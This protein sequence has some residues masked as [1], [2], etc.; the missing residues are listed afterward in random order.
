MIQPLKKV[1]LLFLLLSITNVFGQIN[2]VD[3]IAQV[4]SYWE[5]GEKQNYTISHEKVKLTDSDTTSRELTTYD[6]EVTVLEQTDKS[7]TV[8]WLYKNINTDNTNPTI[9]K[10]LN[11]SKEMTVIFK[12]DELGVFIE[13]VNWQE[14]KDYILKASAALRKEFVNKPE[15]ENILD[16]LEATYS[17][18]TAIESASIRDIQQFHTFH[19][20]Q[21]KLGEFLEG[22]MKVPNIYGPEPFDSDFTVY[23]DEI[24]EENNNFVMRASQEVDKEQLT[25]ATLTYLTTLAEKMKVNPPTKED[26]KELKNETV[27]ASRIHGTGWVIYSVQTITVTAENI[28]NIEERIIEIKEATEK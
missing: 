14:V 13:V 8:Q 5:I 1:L 10:L 16:Q 4:I 6:V 19:G 21:Y 25:S 15:M 7:Y 22:K 28:T 24:N 18:K 17:S 12:T 27:T 20:A 9:Q 11:I 3:S 26:I 2:M 23:L